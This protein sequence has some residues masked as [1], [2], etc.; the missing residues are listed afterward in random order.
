V[1]SDV[2]VFQL[3][4]WRWKGHAH[5][6][7][8]ESG[9]PRVRHHVVH[10]RAIAVALNVGSKS[11]LLWMAPAHCA[12]LLAPHCPAGEALKVLPH[13][14]CHLRRYQVDKGIALS[15]M[16]LEVNGEIHKAELASKSFVV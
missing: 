5:T 12:D 13:F 6:T 10:H 15:S 7:R 16:S 14:F 4:R 11:L 1:V 3:S 9:F 2:R 8:E